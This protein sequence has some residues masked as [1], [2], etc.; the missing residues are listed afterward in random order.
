[1][2]EKFEPKRA[3]VGQPLQLVAVGPK[4]PAVIIGAPR[5]F[6]LRGGEPNV[7]NLAPLRPHPIVKLGA[8]IAAEIT[9]AEH[10]ARRELGRISARW[11][12]KTTR[13]LLVSADLRSKAALWRLRG[14]GSC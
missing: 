6:R 2:S 1:M 7:Q 9:P 11:A 10:Q 13:P 8:E 14:I 3:R 5:M 12:K 4:R